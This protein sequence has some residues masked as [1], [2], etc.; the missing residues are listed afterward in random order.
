MQTSGRKL[1]EHNMRHAAN[2]P[3]R[4]GSR[5]P[6][7]GFRRYNRLRVMQIIRNRRI[8]DVAV[9]GS[10]AGGGM[11]AKVLT[12]AGAD[13]VMLEAGPMWDPVRDSKMFAWNYDSPRRGAAT[14]ERHGGEFDGALGGWT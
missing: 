10:G 8:Y 3:D 13:V 12:E 14:P 11:A 1:A 5:V 7:P 4:G 9:I 6:L 2:W